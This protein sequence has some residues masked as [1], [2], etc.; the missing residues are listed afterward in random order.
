MNLLASNAFLSNWRMSNN[1]PPV[2]GVIMGSQSDWS[3]LEKSTQ[4]LTEFGI[5]WE[6]KVVSAHRTQEQSDS[7][8]PSSQSN[9]LA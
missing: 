4:I 2:V 1:N 9:R 5:P 8:R 3:T 6:A 7:L